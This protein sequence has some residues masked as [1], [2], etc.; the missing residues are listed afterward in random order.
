VLI[1][2]PSDLPD[3]RDAVEK[4]VL[5]WNA[6]HGRKESV[7]LQPW[8]WETSAV[9]V[10]GAHPQQLINAQ[11]VDDSD[12][13][14]ALFNARLG[15]P[16]PTAVSGT[17]EEVDRAL[18]MGKPVHLFFS[19][20]Q[21]PN[22]VDTDQ[23]NALRAFKK[24]MQ[25][26]GLL[27]EF[28]DLDQLRRLVRMA[29][30][31]DVEQVV[32]SGGDHV[33]NVRASD[34]VDAA[35]L[36][37]LSDGAKAMLDLGRSAWL[38]GVGCQRA[39]LTKTAPLARTDVRG[40]LETVLQRMVELLPQQRVD[41]FM[42]L[43]ELGNE[44]NNPR[45][46]LRRWIIRI[47]T[48]YEADARSKFVHVELHQDGSVVFAVQVDGW[49]HEKP[50]P[51]FHKILC[52]VVENFAAEFAALAE[53]YVRRSGSVGPVDYRCDLLTDEELP[54]QAFDLRRLGGGFVASGYEM[55]EGS[56]SVGKFASVTGELPADGEVADLLA[57]ART[58]ATDVVNQFGI[59]R[60]HLLG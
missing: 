40:F 55:V 60:L 8:R 39:P 58:I 14:F 35:R 26:R 24:D 7:F 45:P 51:D 47:P 38:I 13:V 53:T 49:G 29:I 57:A 31:H 48:T 43:R 1:A 17:V 9:P 46:G 25:D 36:T 3:A 41:R 23:L 15:S 6:E 32:P 18:R 10:L 19:T 34:P 28:G 16:T 2:S 5:E 50:V 44:V 27:G 56:W 12:I 59:G 21:L 30:T 42:I 11:G 37:A 4:V 54:L 20:G 52:P 33:G 22:D